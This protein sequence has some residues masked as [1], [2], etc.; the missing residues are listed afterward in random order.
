VADPDLGLG[1]WIGG[2]NELAVVLAGAVSGGYLAANFASLWDVEYFHIQ[3]MAGQTVSEL[4]QG[5]SE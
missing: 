2:D 1:A 3:G 4:G 5:L